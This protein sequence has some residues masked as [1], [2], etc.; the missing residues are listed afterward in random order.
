VDAKN[1]ERQASLGTSLSIWQT[2]AKDKKTVSP[3]EMA[4]HEMKTPLNASLSLSFCLK[5]LSFC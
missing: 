2:I 5:F 4:K 3:Q 1:A